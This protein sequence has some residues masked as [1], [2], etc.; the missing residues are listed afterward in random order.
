MLDNAPNEPNERSKFKTKNWVEV[1]D[2]SYGAY[3]TGRETSFKTS[4][5]RSSLCGYNDA[6]VLIKGTIKFANTAAEGAAPNNRNK[7]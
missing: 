2:G 6:N 1:N 4:I 7:K 5:I 3:S